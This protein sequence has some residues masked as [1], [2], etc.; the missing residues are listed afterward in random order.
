MIKS[1]GFTEQFIRTWRF[2]FCY[3]IAGFQQSYINNIHALW[4]KGTE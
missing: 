2:Y 1:L 4:Q 3:C